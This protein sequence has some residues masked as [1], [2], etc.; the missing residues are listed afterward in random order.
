MFQLTELAPMRQTAQSDVGAFGYGVQERVRLDQTGRPHDRQQ[1]GDVHQRQSHAL[2]D[3]VVFVGVGVAPVA[4]AAEDLHFRREKRVSA[5]K[6]HQRSL[7]ECD[8][9]AGNARSGG[10]LV[11]VA[12]M[13]R[14]SVFRKRVCRETCGTLPPVCR[15]RTDGQCPK[16]DR[17]SVRLIIAL[18]CQILPFPS[19]GS[20]TGG[21][22]P[23]CPR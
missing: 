10:L 12:G 11:T 13:I 19:L 20:R 5:Q 16:W 15:A 17:R 22:D 7:E 14:G 18:K 21:P 2:H 8:Q 9:C 23:T 1:I 6:L 4:N 3:Q